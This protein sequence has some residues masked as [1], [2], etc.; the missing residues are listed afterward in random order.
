MQKDHLQPAQ[1]KKIVYQDFI[2]DDHQTLSVFNLSLISSSQ[3]VFFSPQV[4][5]TRQVIG[6]DIF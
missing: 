2:K 4:M 1:R 6:L 5:I 3:A